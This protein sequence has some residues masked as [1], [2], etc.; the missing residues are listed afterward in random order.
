[1]YSMGDDRSRYKHFLRVIVSFN[2]GA[3]LKIDVPQTMKNGI[4]ARIKVRYER[5]PQYCTFCGRMGHNSN[6]CCKKVEE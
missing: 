1:M 3:P 2:V 5:L 4:E 6:L